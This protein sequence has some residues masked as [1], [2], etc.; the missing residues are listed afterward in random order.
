MPQ[1]GH[2]VLTQVPAAIGPAEAIIFL[3]L[4]IGPGVLVWRLADSRNARNPWIWGLV[5]FLL[6]PL[7]LLLLLA[8]PRGQGG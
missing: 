7:G 1:G 4:F 5:A 3:A 2:V 8:V 6:G